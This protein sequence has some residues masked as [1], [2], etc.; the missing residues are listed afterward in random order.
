MPIVSAKKRVSVRG[1]LTHLSPLAIEGTQ[2]AVTQN[3]WQA[4]LKPMNL[5]FP[6]RLGPLGTPSCWSQNWVFHPPQPFEGLGQ[7]MRSE[8]GLNTLVG[9]PHEADGPGE[10]GLVLH[11][12]R[13]VMG[14]TLP[15]VREPSWGLVCPKSSWRVSQSQGEAGR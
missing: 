5:A 3:G 13:G 2:T 12:F 11:P 7:P 9:K 4:E 15:Q 14:P 10:A 1:A 6:S 8:T